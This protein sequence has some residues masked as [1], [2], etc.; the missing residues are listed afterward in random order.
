MRLVAGIGLW[1]AMA[2]TPAAASD[3]Y[4][5][6]MS[7]DNSNISFVD[8]DS[9]RDNGGGR[10]VGAIFSLLDAADEDGLIAYRFTVEFDCPA[11]RSRMLM[12]EAF[13]PD[14]SSLGEEVVPDDWKPVSP[15]TQG[16][17][18]AHF[19]CSKGTDGARAKSAGS[20]LPFDAGRAVLD[21]SRK[22]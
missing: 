17:R 22:Q 12:F 15:D 21:M 7:S 4:F 13:K 6:D 20:A 10:T 5:I 19:I 16:G 2:A 8:K 18:F 14:R 11:M 3:W 1:L 9:I